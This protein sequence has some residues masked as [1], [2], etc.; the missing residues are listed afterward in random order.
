M[1]NQRRF[2]LSHHRSPGDIVCLT[3]LARDIKA[4]YGNDVLIDAH[5]TCMDLWRNNPHLTP[6]WDHRQHRP[7]NNNAHVLKLSYGQG[8]RQHKRETVH[9][10]AYFHRDFHK[11]T[12]LAVPV[13]LPYGDLHLSETERGSSLINGRY[14]IVISGGKSDFTIKVWRQK[15]FQEVT[16]GLAKHGI[17]FVQIGSTDAGHWH[18][19]LANTLNLVGQTNLRDMLRLIYHADGVICGVTGAM[20]MAAALQRPCVCIAGGREA[21]WWE[22]YVRE[23]KG[24]GPG[25]EQK[26]TVPHRFLHTIGLLSCCQNIGCWRNKVAPTSKDPLLC[27]MPVVHPDMA[28]AK[29]MDMITPDMVINAVLSYYCD[30]T[31]TMP[32]MATTA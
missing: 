8:I 24:F 26:L 25:V 4:A 12:G 30:G 2:I 19:E 6:L 3:A 5:T 23:N 29:C 21:W 9:F 15:A 11:Q 1:A 22:A 27:H 20:H 17:Q 10:A 32:Q 16:D 18:P 31:L 13:T 28:I 14:W 7:I